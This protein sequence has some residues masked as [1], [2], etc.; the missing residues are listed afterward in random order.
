MI[1]VGIVVVQ[2]VALKKN[3]YTRYLFWGL[4]VLSKWYMVSVNWNC[5]GSCLEIESLCQVFVWGLAC[6]Q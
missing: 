4:L 5:A 6:L 1:S 2:E 3:V